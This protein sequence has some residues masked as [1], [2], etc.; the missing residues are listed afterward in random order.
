MKK[1]FYLLITLLFTTGCGLQQQQ[2]LKR[3]EAALN[4]KEQQLIARENAVDLKE[5]ELVKREQRLDSSLLKDTAM[6]YDSTLLGKWSVTMNCIEATCPGSAVGDTKTEQWNISFTDN[7]VVAKVLTDGS[8]VRIYSG[9]YN[10]SLLELSVPTN[11]SAEKKVATMAVR[12]QHATPNQLE[13][14]REITRPEG[15]RIV[16]AIRMDKQEATKTN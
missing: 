7:Q 4:T 13:G 3:R 14:R 10:G 8:L 15:C 12:L 16:Y 11:D 5:K 9:T 6:V 2:E 1:V